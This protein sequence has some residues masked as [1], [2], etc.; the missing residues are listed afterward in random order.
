MH[1]QNPKLSQNV[2]N[3]IAAGEVID[4]PASVVRELLDNSIDS[5]A[6]R[7]TIRIEDGGS[8]LIRVSD[9]GAG[10]DRDDL[11]LAIERHA[12]SKISTASDIFTIKT[13]GSGARRFRAYALFQG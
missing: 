8:G 6:D 13:L 7:I 2:A 12:T 5:G 9:N 11:L 1:G 4:R 3:Q 10:M